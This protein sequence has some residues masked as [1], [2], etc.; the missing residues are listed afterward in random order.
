MN[1]QQKTAVTIVLVAVIVVA[2]L[3]I[4]ENWVLNPSDTII[5]T[6]SWQ[7]PIQ[8]FATT[9][10]CADGKVF[11]TDGQYNVNCYDAK[12]GRSIWNGTGLGLVVSKNLA[13]ADGVVCSGMKSGAVGCVD[14]ATGQ[15][16]WYQ[17]GTKSRFGVPDALINNGVVFGISDSGGFVTAFNA[18]TG[19]LI[20]EAER[21]FGPPTATSRAS[22]VG[23]L[24]VS[25]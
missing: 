11:T 21:Y 1:R 15:S 19:E 12:T 3:V 10:T 24:M 6:G 5:Q 13:V 18:S 9:L 14:E 23:Q 16:K 22:T 20:W 25:R 8:N 2:S 4:Y 7:R 17:S